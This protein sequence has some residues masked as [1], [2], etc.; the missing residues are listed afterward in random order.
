VNG[1]AQASA[2]SRSLEIMQLT[3]YESQ[4]LSVKGNVRLIRLKLCL[5]CQAMARS[6]SPDPNRTAARTGQ[7]PVIISGSVVL[8]EQI[9]SRREGEGRR[10]RGCIRS[11]TSALAQL[12]YIESR[13]YRLYPAQSGPHICAL[14]L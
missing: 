8:T 10:L 14:L 9:G 1:G 2:P 13:W 7:F 12:I 5:T 11:A 4:P 6:V 3:R